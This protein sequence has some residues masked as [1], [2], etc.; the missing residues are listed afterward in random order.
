MKVHINISIENSFISYR[1]MKIMRKQT[2]NDIDIP[3]CITRIIINT[4]EMMIDRQ[5]INNTDKTI[6]KV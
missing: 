6:G 1:V 2:G 4:G 5:D 3:T